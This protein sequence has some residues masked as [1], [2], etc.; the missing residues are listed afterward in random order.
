MD[1]LAQQ[2]EFLAEMDKLKQIIRQTPLLDGSRL[3][4][5]AEHS[6]HLAMLVIVLGEYAE[7]PVDLTRALKMV[8]VHD[9]VEIDA[10]DTFCYHPTAHDDKAERELR[11]AERLFGL[12]PAEQGR[13]LRELWDEFEARQSNEARFANAVDRVQPLLHNCLTGG[14]G[15]KRH[16]VQLS[17]VLKRNRPILQGAPLL[18][19]YMQGLLRQ[20][21]ERGHLPDDSDGAA[22]DAE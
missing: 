10:G 17:Q 21:V 9:I 11:A 15:W 8:L 16:G 14:L 7:K 13:E 22:W 5:D 1:R 18:W 12:L 19:D 6:W 3:E 20:A 4:N 2:F